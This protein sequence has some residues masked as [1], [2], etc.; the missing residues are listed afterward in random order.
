MVRFDFADRFH[1]APEAQFGSSRRL[2]YIVLE[3]TTVPRW[4]WALRTTVSMLRLAFLQ[5]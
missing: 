1:I 4:R 3:I 2:E 5:L